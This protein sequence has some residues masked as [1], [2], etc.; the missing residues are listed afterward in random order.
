M[1]CRCPFSDPQEKTQKAKQLRVCDVQAYS[2][3]ILYQR[4]SA[5]FLLKLLPLGLTLT[6]S[7]GSYCMLFASKQGRDRVRGLAG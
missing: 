6:H 1:D 7:S 3:Q 2:L 5:G 4:N